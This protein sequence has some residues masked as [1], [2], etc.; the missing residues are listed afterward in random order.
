MKPP[1]YVRSLTD[2]ERA[3]LRDGLR[4][5]DA[6]VLR[7]CQIL[8]A[9]ADRQQVPDI[10]R[11]LGCNRQTVRNAIHAFN[12]DGLACLRPGSSRPHTIR[13]AFD[14]ARAEALRELLHRSPR[15]FGHPTSLW[16]LELAA[17]VSFA[18]GLTP[19]RVSDE[20]IRATLARLGVRWRR[21]KQ[22]ITSPDPAYRRKK[23]G[24]TA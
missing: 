1:I 22:W 16:T 12:A 2:A 17:E 3:A 8:L 4:C 24:A 9:S 14:T 23:A 15:D 10:A 19:T 5:A 13:V 21:A 6:F 7:R 20:T 18:E 11:A